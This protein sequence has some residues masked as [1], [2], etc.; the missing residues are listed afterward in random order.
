MADPTHSMADPTNRVY[1]CPVELSLDLIASKWK[2]TL[3]RHLQS[4]VSSV[5][6]LERQMPL[7]TPKTVDLLLRELEQDGL[8][9]QTLH[10]DEPSREEF[11]LTE[12]GTRMAPVIDY[13]V[14]F[15]REYARLNAIEILDDSAHGN[16]DTV[17]NDSDGD[18]GSTRN[19][20]W[21]AW[22]WLPL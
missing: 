20:R 10:S 14:S 17:G 21:L 9:E 7:T 2:P 19:G 11:S 12:T 1:Y 15:G 22:S 8:V 13:M 3:L 4:G 18:D 16:S 6:D 5:G